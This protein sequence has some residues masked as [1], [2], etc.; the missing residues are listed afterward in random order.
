MENDT[1][2][3]MESYLDN[4][5]NNNWTKIS[6]LV[7]KCDWYVYNSDFYDVDCNRPENYIVTNS[8]SIVGFRTDN[9]IWDFKYL[10]IREISPPFQ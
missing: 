1:S 9:I 3:K 8:G 10:S 2:V 7:D 6:S 5:G 4:N